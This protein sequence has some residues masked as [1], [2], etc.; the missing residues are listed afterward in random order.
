MIATLTHNLAK[1]FQVSAQYTWSKAMDEGSGPYEEDPYPY[2]TSAAYGRSDY[3][4]KNAFKLFG[5]W[6]PVFFHGSRG[7]LEKVAGGWSVSGILNLHSGFPWNPIY[8]TN[9]VYYQGSGYGQIRPDG[10]APGEGFST[11][12]KV[13]EQATNPNYGG[14]GT[15]FLL[16]PS[17]VQGPAFP[18]FAP[19]PQPGIQR[20]SLNGPRYRDLDASLTKAFGLPRVKGLGENAK[21]EVRADI[22]NLFNTTNLNV[23]QID[24]NLGSVA[25]NGTG[26]FTV[27]PNSDFGVIGQALGSRTIQLQARFSF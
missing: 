23:S 4:V 12:N 18:F 8:N 13:F 15:A 5:L 1:S 17:Y 22:Y 25:P 14:N 19:A 20:N 6:Q 3:N 9:G 2:D 26:G 10:I 11:D 24:N 21:F 7:W 16:P 27:S